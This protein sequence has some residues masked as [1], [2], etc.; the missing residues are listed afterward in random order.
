M[1]KKQHIVTYSADE[2]ASMKSETDWARV[3]A[4]AQAEVDTRADKEV[5]T[6]ADKEDGV[7]LDGWE[8]SVMIGL[9]KG[10]EAVK[11]RVDRDVLHWFRGTGRGYQTRMNNVLRAFVQSR[12]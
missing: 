9:P 4:M 8:K 7:L 6:R 10:K 12:Q 3:D 11:L 5:D 1:S 2:L